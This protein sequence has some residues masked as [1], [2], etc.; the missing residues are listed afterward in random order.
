MSLN[1]DTK[2]R[3][4][5]LKKAAAFIKKCRED[6]HQIPEIANKEFKTHDYIKERLN[7]MQIRYE[8]HATGIIGFLPANEITDGTKGAVAFRSDIDALPVTE[9]TENPHPSLHEGMMHACGHDGHMA[10]LLGWAK[11]LTDENAKRTRDVVFIFQPAEENP[12]GA[13]ILVD[14]G[15][16]QKYGVDEVFGIHLNSIVEEGKLATCAG[17]MMADNT[18]FRITV[19]GT[20][21]HA[22]MPHMGTDTVLASAHLLTQLQQIV[23]R[24]SDP[25]ETVVLSVGLI[26]GGVQ[27]NV[28]AKETYME[29]T[30]RTFSREAARL[31]VERMEQICEGI[32]TSHN[33]RAKFKILAK[34]PAVVNDEKLTQEFFDLNE[35]A[36][37][38]L[39]Q[40]I[41][42]DFSEYQKVVPGL[43]FYVGTKNEEKGLVHSL[44]SPHFD[45]VPDAL[46]NG[47]KAYLNL[48]MSRGDLDF[49]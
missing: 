43:F 2:K 12:G 35:N 15:F 42:E 39:P 4:N 24:N 44:H 40:M 5:T 18:V 38:I 13:K 10:M 33:V 29:G 8:T 17:P 19:T 22:A 32:S 49:K 37:T 7:E 3:D 20:G 48:L 36:E 46:L 47:P 14:T 1:I 9:Q 16:M 21:S 45:F 31:A 11:I 23:S 28:L 41:S 27:L 6:L 30:L 34:Y 26:R 25:H